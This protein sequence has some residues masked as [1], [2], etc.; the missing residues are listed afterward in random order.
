[1]PTIRYTRTKARK[2][3]FNVLKE[4]RPCQDCRNVYPSVCMDW[5]HRPGSNKRSAVSVMIQQGLGE[6]TILMEIAKCDLV[7][8]N[9]HRIRTAARRQHK[10]AS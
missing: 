3:L 2:A 9:C 7:C 6:E 4:G 1:M 10:N 8:S 5:D